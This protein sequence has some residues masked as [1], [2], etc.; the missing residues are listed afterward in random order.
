[1]LAAF[2]SS[3][4]GKKLPLR[5]RVDRLFFGHRRREK[6]R[7]SFHPVRNREPLWGGGFHNT[8][9]IN[10]GRAG[11]GRSTKC[12]TRC[13]L[14]A[15][16]AYSRSACSASEAKHYT[17][18]TTHAT[19][20]DQSNIFA[21][22]SGNVGIG[23]N[24]PA[25]M[26]DVRGATA[27][28]LLRSEITSGSGSAIYGHA[29][30]QNIG[31]QGTCDGGAGGIAVQGQ[32]YGAATGGFFTS[33]SGLALRTYGGNVQIDGK[34][35]IGT[36]IPSGKLAV[37]GGTPDAG[38]LFNVHNANGQVIGRIYPDGSNNGVLHVRDSAGNVKI[39]LYSQGSSYFMGANVGIGKTN[40]GSKL[41]VV[42]LPTSSAGLT[43]GDIWR[44]AANGNVLKIVS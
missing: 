8:K 16:Q 26:L 44:D 7:K 31:V 6:T 35:G 19:A 17:R 21:A 13:R 23:T 11:L 15:R 10:N 27:N 18:D 40:P 4:P 33:Q 36:S 24:N 12:R 43:S 37:Q 30:N 38:D 14:Y 5:F 42:G 3:L 41:S 32:A 9:I 39:Q 29:T 28:Y 34:V 22:D 2:R 25:A 20:V 1:V